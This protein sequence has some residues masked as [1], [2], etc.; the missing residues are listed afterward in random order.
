ML[1]VSLPRAHHQRQTLVGQVGILLVVLLTV[2]FV[3]SYFYMLF[4]FIWTCFGQQSVSVAAA[5][6]LTERRLGRWTRRRRFDLA[7][8]KD[9]RASPESGGPWSWNQPRLWY[10]WTDAYGTLAFD[11]GARTYPGTGQGIDEA[12]ARMVVREIIAR[13]PQL[14]AH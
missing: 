6:F 12:E 4:V 1:S 3:V 10:W 8:V 13:F 14:A 11:Y 2:F 5:E 9:F 7:H